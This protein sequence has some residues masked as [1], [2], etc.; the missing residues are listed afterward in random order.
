M[1][2][3]QALYHEGAL[4]DS[5]HELAKLSH[6]TANPNYRSLHVHLCIALGDWNS[7]SEFVA[8]ELAQRVDRSADDLNACGPASPPDRFAAS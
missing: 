1:S 4:L 8:N 5:R 6:N 3:A 2:Y 7:L